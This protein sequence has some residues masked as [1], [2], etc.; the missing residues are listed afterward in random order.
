MKVAALKEELSR[1][2]TAHRVDHCLGLGSQGST[3]GGRDCTRQ[4]R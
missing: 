1:G 3:V 4:S 2:W